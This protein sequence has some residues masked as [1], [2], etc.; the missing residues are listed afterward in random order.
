MS[1]LTIN[2]AFF[3]C[4]SRQGLVKLLQNKAGKP[5][6]NSMMQFICVIH[7]E[8]VCEKSL[9]MDN[10]MSAVTKTVKFIRSKGS[11]GTTAKYVGLAVVK[12]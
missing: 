9:K 11:K 8:N 2:K 1:A 3:M 6:N 10:I 7:Q 5:E 12:C 4:G